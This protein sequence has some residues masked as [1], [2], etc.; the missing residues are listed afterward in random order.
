MKKK[1]ERYFIVFYNFFVK[2]YGVAVKSGFGTLHYS[3]PGTFPSGKESTDL[4]K[5]FLNDDNAEVCITN[6]LELKSRDFLSWIKE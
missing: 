1:K 2:Q 3:T 4:A 5:S 6:I